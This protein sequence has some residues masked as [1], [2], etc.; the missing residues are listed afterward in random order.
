MNSL[1]QFLCRNEERHSDDCNSG[2]D[3]KR[4]IF[5]KTGKALA[6]VGFWRPGFSQTEYLYNFL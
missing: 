4:R 5:I 3:Q 2:V 1:N 6:R